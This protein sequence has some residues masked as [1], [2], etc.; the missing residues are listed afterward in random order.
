MHFAIQSASNQP[1]R[2]FIVEDDVNTLRRLCEQFQ[3]DGRTELVG[4]AVDVGQAKQML[5]K[6]SCDIALVDLGLPDASGLEIIRHIDHMHPAT[7]SLVL[8]M[9]GE[10]SYVLEAVR[11][12]ASG[13]L[14]KG[15]SD[16]NRLV[17]EVIAV[18]QGSAPISP[19]LARHILQAVRTEKKHQSRNLSAEN[20]SEKNSDLTARE[21]ELLK[22]V[23]QGFV[24]KEIS[25]KLFLSPHTVTTHFKNVY[26][27]L[28]VKTRGEAVFKA[29][30][31]GLI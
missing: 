25:K 23:S 16:A 1:V 8:S 24:V 27:K 5:S 19:S 22:L 29:R 6:V 14:L 10:A 2:V 9:F 15:E 28:H 18:S 13:Y 21:C 17:D 7:E 12:G 20:S 3:K 26:K 4:T 31:C 30:A 11:A